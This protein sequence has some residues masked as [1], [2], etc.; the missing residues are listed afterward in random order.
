LSAKGIVI[1]IDDFGSGYSS[2]GYLSKLP[3]GILKIDRSFVSGIDRG[4]EDAAV[5]QAI[6]RLGHTLG[7]EVVAEGIETADQLAELTRRGCMLGQG[8]LLGHPAPV[9]DSVA[10]STES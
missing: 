6:I 2:L 8:F 3:I 7:L 1:A 5:A 9:E 4:P 10:S